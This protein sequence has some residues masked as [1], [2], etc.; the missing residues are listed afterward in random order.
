MS[1][2]KLI[3]L[4]L[5]IYAIYSIF[6]FIF[7]IRKNLNYHKKQQES[8]KNQSNRH[9]NAGNTIIELKDDQYK[10]E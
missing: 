9:A 2:F 7:T 5:F 10:V 6:K 1:F 4:G 8:K 3:L